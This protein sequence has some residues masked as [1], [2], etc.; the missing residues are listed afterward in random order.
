M[1]RHV[2]VAPVCNTMIQPYKSIFAVFGQ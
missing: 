1:V 2:R